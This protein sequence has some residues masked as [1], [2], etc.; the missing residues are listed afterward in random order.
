M[1]VST[2]WNTHPGP[3]VALPAVSSPLASELCWLLDEP[4]RGTR[5]AQTRLAARTPRR[6]RRRRW[7]RCLETYNRQ[8]YANAARA[9]RQSQRS[10][11]RTPQYVQLARDR[12]FGGLA[13]QSLGLVAAVCLRA[14]YWSNVVQRSATS[15]FGETT[16][17]CPRRPNPTSSACALAC[18]RR[19]ARRESTRSS[20]RR[21]ACDAWTPPSR[22][23]TATA[24]RA[25]ATPGRRAR[26]EETT[27]GT[28]R[29]RSTRTNA[30]LG[31]SDVGNGWAG[32]LGHRRVGA[33]SRAR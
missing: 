28:R 10:T 2:D 33:V 7:P 17:S 29:R 13:D 27:S 21:V 3:L 24:S 30:W 11:A 31:R 25:A 20:R 6:R 9:V 4:A 32:A 16:T 15:T 19:A 12:R 14:A 26:G 8:R 1:L 5:C 23:P 22:P 18:A